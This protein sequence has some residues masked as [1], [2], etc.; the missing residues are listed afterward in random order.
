MRLW[1]LHP[2]YLDAQGLTALWRE[3]L[4]ARAV[5]CG[6]TRGY[7]HHPQLVRFQAQRE[8]AAAIA[9]YLQ[10][11]YA[12]SVARGYRFDGSKLDVVHGDMRISTTRG[13][14][15]YEWRHLLAKLE[16]R[17]PATFRNRAELQPQP[18]PM[19]D[20]VSGPPEPWERR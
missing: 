2:R 11:V 15:E 10:A 19:F 3:S 12:E 13:Q 20:I 7:R 9:T 8:P 4:L 18:H 17:S 14:L 1:T 5:L 6:Q 16:T